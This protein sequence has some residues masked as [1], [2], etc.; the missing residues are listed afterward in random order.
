MDNTLGRTVNG[1]IGMLSVLC[2]EHHPTLKVENI[3]ESS[4]T[5]TI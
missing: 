3:R 4:L 5:Y 2:L 1:N